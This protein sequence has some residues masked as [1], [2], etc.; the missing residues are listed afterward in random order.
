MRHGR[1]IELPMKRPWTTQD[2]QAL[3]AMYVRSDTAIQKIRDTIHRSG[4]DIHTRAA[5][6]GLVRPGREE[7]SLQKVAPKEVKT[8]RPLVRPPS[9][10]AIM[11]L[12]RLGYAPVF[13]QRISETSTELTGQWIVGN[14]VLS[15]AEV[16][17]LAAKHRARRSG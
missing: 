17:A 9:P 15:P 6:L 2:D 14:H 16:E 8:P 3:R 4:P 1:G 7:Q 12:R 5:E 13:A 11:E 10:A